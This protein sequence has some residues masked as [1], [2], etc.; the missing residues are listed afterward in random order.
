MSDV[1]GQLD[2]V[3]A[4]WSQ[5]PLIEFQGFLTHGVV[6]RLVATLGGVFAMF[7]RVRAGDGCLMVRPLVVFHDSEHHGFAAAALSANF[8]SLGTI[9]DG[10]GATATAGRKLLLEARVDA[11]CAVALVM[12]ELLDMTGSRNCC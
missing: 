10:M 1:S 11:V 2:R 8:S 7:T 5:V 12:L 4:V 9:W 3:E 6:R